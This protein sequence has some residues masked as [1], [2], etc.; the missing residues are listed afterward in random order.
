LW[1]TDVGHIINAGSLFS[2]WFSFR[3]ECSFPKTAARNAIAWM[4][5]PRPLFQISN[6]K[7]ELQHSNYL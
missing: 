1:I 7:N 5:F 6:L 2:S 3:A 4:V